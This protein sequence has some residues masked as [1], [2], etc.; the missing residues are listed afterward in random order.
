VKEILLAQFKSDFVMEVVLFQGFM[1]LALLSFWVVSLWRSFQRTLSS[2]GLDRVWFLLSVVFGFFLGLIFAADWGSEYYL[3]AFALG[4]S[5][6][7]A[8][9]HPSMAVCLLLSLLFLRP[10]ELIDKN[11]YFMILPKLTFSLCIAHVILI[12]ARRRTLALRWNVTTLYLA[13]FA[14]WAFF[15]TL[16]APDPDASQFRYFDAFFK[17]L[18]LY[19]MIL[20]ILESETDLRTLQGTMVLTFLGV[21]LISIYQTIN[22]IAYKEAGMRLQGIGAFSNSN[23]IAALMVLVFPFA[24]FPL[25][26]KTE[27]P[28][29]RLLS[30]VVLVVVV[31]SIVMAKSRGAILSLQRD[32]RNFYRSA[33]HDSAF[34]TQLR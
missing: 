27:H 29:H 7:L 13:A 34:F 30:A 20:N 3:L 12:Q 10:W 9:T 1:F 25:L 15:S 31:A 5:L 33:R 2:D 24:L 23:D 8:L 16:V 6:G 14:I 18:F 11:D 22:L 21:G 19:V 17:A 32:R 28:L 4:L 26:R